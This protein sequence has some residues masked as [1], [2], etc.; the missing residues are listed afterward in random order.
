[1]GLVWCGTVEEHQSD[2]PE[3][4]SMKEGEEE[5]WDWTNPST[6]EECRRSPSDFEASLL[7]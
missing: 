7:G 5:V 4:W 2:L 1:M 3:L 6:W